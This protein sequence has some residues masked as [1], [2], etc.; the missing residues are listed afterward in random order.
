MYIRQPAVAGSFYPEGEEQLSVLVTQMLSEAVA[1]DAV[2]VC[3]KVLICPHAGYVYSGAIAASGYSQLKAY[4]QQIS[5]VVLLGPSHRVPLQGIAIPDTSLFRTPLGEIEVDQ[6]ALTKIKTLEGVKVS[7]HAHAYE[8]SLEVQLPFLQC[9][10]DDFKIIPLVVGQAGPTLVSKVIDVLWGGEETLFVVSTDLSHYHNYEHAKAVDGET[11]K[12]IEHF[13]TDITCDH[14]C[15]CY[16][17]NGMMQ[18]AQHHRMHISQL[19]LRNSG[20]TAGSKDQ[21]VGYAAYALF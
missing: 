15:G 1:N 21:V 8:H 18:A 12:K 11:C 10:L 19:D 14:A 6:E 2:Q 3:P 7:P 20:D 4:H 9:V 16:P 17:L 5:R 13:D